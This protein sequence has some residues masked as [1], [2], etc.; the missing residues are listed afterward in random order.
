MNVVA[1][2]DKL[3]ADLSQLRKIFNER[4]L[5]EVHDRR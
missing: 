5:Y 2:M 4:I 1:L 3:D